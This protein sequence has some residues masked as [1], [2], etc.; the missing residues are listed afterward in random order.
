MPTKVHPIEAKIIK[1]SEAMDKDPKLKGTEAAAKFRAPYDRLMARR[2]G[3]PASHTRGGKN[4]KLLALQD[5][6]LRDYCF[7]LHVSRRNPN[8]EVIQ[9]AA[10][11]LVYY[12]TG[13]IDSIVLRR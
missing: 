2:R 4:K 9:T 13:D 5:A 8:L 1:A 7:M 11:R 3:R 10:S 12:K 6:S